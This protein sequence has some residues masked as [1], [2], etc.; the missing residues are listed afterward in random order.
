MDEY[1]EEVVGPLCAWGIVASPSITDA[2]HIKVSDGEYFNRHDSNE[3]LGADPISFNAIYLDSNSHTAF[4]DVNITDID[5]TR[6]RL[7]NATLGLMT[8][9]WFRKDLLVVSKAPIGETY[10]IVYGDYEYEQQAECEIQ[11]NPTKPATTN[12]YTMNVAAIIVQQGVGVVSVVDQRPFIGQSSSSMLSAGD[13]Y[14]PAAATVDNIVVFDNVSGKRIKDSGYSI[15]DLLGATG[16]TGVAG[17]TGSEGPTGS[18]GPI[19]ETGPIGIGNTGPTGI[20]GP[21]GSVG[22]TGIT[23]AT[24]ANGSQGPTGQTGASGLTGATGANGQAG[25]TG[26]VGA[27]GPTG[28]TGST[29]S[30]YPWEGSWT[31]STNYHLNDCVQESGSSYVCLTAHTSATF[32]SDLSGGKWSLVTQRGATGQTGNSGITGPNGRNW[33]DWNDWFN[34]ANG[35]WWLRFTWPYRANWCRYYGIRWSDRSYGHCRSHRLY[36]SVGHWWYRSNRNTGSY[37]FYWTDGFN[38]CHRSNWAYWANWI[39]G[40]YRRHW[41]NRNDRTHWCDWSNR[42]DWCNWSYW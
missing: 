11:E 25:T 21:T 15:I 1:L 3:I 41:F 28:S 39:H 8:P 4:Q 12:K 23:G 14:G 27:T 33:T 7:P 13:V 32:S 31:T 17:P 6:Y 36:G 22:Q 26:S 19:G 30:Q 20:Q 35:C 40:S 2:R 42:I 18:Q 38:R 5:I 24:G 37:W 9:G 29:G 34:W 10:T 16:A